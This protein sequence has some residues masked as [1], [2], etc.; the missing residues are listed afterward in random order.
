M[1][2]M[3]LGR[4]VVRRQVIV[5]AGGARSGT[6]TA[7][8]PAKDVLPCVGLVQQLTPTALDATTVTYSFPASAIG[9]GSEVT[10]VGRR[11]PR[12]L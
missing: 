11:S 12:R 9:S 8:D 6:S 7:A 2:K 5:F 1:G 4:W 3:K 10:R